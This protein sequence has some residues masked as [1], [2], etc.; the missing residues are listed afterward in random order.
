MPIV[1]EPKDKQLFFEALMDKY[2]T[3]GRDRPRGFFPRIDQV[4][5]YEM[6]IERITGKELELPAPS[7]AMASP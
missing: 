6:T 2:G 3:P 7:H 1:S 4:T 5:V